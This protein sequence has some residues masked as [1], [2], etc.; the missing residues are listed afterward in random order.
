MSHGEA[1]IALQF[2]RLP[3]G[4]ASDVTVSGLDEPPRIKLFGIDE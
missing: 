3:E 4:F 1:N 2:A